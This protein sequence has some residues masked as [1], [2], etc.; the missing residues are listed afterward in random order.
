MIFQASDLKGNYFPDLLD[1]NYLP[2]KPTYSKGS[3]WLKLFGYSN[4]LYA[5][6]TRAITNH[7]PIREY[8]LRSFLREIFSC[9]YRLYPIEL[10]H[11]VLY[12]CRRYNNYWNSNRVF[13]SH[14]VLFL[15]YNLE[16]FSFHKEVT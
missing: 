11:H 16:A 7:A 1:N 6:A 13:L 14:F 4:F 3:L 8:Y 2:V 10:R 5:R 12:K 9:L 15:K